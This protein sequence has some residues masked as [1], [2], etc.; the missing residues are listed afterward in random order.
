MDCTNGI[1]KVK[2]ERE[3]GEE[4]DEEEEEKKVILFPLRWIIFFSSDRTL[5]F[6]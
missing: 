2:E 5:R 4:E 1:Y 6:L 3:L